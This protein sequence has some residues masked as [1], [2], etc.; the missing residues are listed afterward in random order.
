MDKRSLRGFATGI[1]FALGILGTFYYSFLPKET[2]SFSNQAAKV[3]V[4][5][6]G[7]V[8][9]KK[10]EYTA[11]KNKA[12]LTKSKSVT[13]KKGTSETKTEESAKKESSYRLE[14]KSGMNTED[15]VHELAVQKIIENEKE[16]A[17][18]L[19]QHHYE[20]KV[21]LGSF[22]VTSGMDYEKI[23]RIITKQ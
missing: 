5:K 11:L 19:T 13:G 20:S 12:S 4:E 10:N 2:T 14:I 6:N 18:Y 8:V 1:I 3:Q 21:Q 23:A 17:F 9:M 16:F 22:E 7:Y 15:I